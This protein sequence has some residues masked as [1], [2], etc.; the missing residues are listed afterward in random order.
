MATLLETPWKLR[1]REPLAKKVGTLYQKLTV[2]LANGA[3]APLDH[4]RGNL[5][6]N[7][8]GA[9]RAQTP[10]ELEDPVALIDSGRKRERV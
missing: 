9:Q 3:V 7:R 6:G 5:L 1:S 4:V 8:K 10:A 2:A